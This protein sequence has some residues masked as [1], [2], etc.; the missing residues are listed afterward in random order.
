MNK[1]CI[2]KALLEKH[3]KSFH[4][5]V[6][7][8][9]REHAPHRLYLPSDISIVQMHKD[10]AEQNKNIKCSYY[11]YRPFVKDVM[12]IYFTKLGPEECEHCERY[13]NNMTRCIQ[14]ITWIWK[15]AVHA[16]NGTFVPTKLRMQG[17]H[18]EQIPIRHNGELRIFVCRRTF[19]KS[20]CSH[21]QTLSNRYLFNQFSNI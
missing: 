14:K 8:Y 16:K 10:F 9:R 11:T 12:K 21:A 2:D 6:S 13:L 20:L 17:K 5:C 4:P 15:I 7:H 18:I 1:K 19:R 3:V